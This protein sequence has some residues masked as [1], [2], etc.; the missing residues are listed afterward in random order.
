M[1]LKMIIQNDIAQELEN[2]ILKI[3]PDKVCAFIGET[4]M[5]SIE[6]LSP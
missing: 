4:M 2:K 3:G 1:N 5:G 6:M